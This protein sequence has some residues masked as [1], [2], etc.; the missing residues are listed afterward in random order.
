MNPKRWT[1]LS[2]VLLLAIIAGL[3]MWYN[4]I[5][6]G[7]WAAEAQAKKQ[8]MEQAALTEVDS[9]EKYVW[10]EAVW[11][12]E[13][14]T[15]DGVEQYVWLRNSGTETVRAADAATKQQIRESLLQNKPDAHI[16]HIRPGIVNGQHVWEA[17]YSRSEG[18]QQKY[19]Y[20]FYSF[21]NG[22]FMNTLK[23][24]EKQLAQ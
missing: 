16:K 13:G 19:A 23:L 14:K 4:T 15:A 5:F 6:R 22:T 2:L 21:E 17:F 12:V 9:T 3:G 24:P 18:G 20:D 1:A 11:V 10:D 8:A 7:I